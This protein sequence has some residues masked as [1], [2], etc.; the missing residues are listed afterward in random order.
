MVSLLALS[1]TPLLLVNLVFAA[2]ALAVGFAAGAWVCGG[3]ESTEGRKDLS[4]EDA[5]LE[6]ER[7]NQ[8]LERTVMASDRL[9][10]LAVSVASDVGSHNANIGLIEAQLEQGRADG[11][12]NAELVL[13]AIDE[14]EQA[15]SSLQSKLEKAEQQIKA[16]A[17]QIKTHESEAR[18]D[19]LTSLANRRA[20]DDELARRLAEW[21]RLKTPFSLL[22]MDVDHFKQFNDTHGHLAGDEVLRQVGHAMIECAREMDLPCRYGGEEFAII[23]PATRSSDGGV[24]AERLRTTIETMQVPFEGKKLSV[25]VSMGLSGTIE[26]DSATELVKRADEALYAS[27]DAG[28]N[29]THLNNGKKNL[30]VTAGGPM[31]TLSDEVGANVRAPN[32][33]SL[34]NRTRFLELIRNEIRVAKRCESPL[35]LLVT[36]FEGYQRI[37][38]EFGEAV[39]NLTLDSISQFLDNAIQENDQLCQLGANQFFILMPQHSAKEAHL[40]GERINSALS[41][42]AIPL[43]TE[44]LRLSMRISSVELD[45]QDTGT[46]LMK[47]AERCFTTPTVTPA[48]AV[49][50]S[51]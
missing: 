16:Q 2:I 1:S 25:T 31:P 38:S 13:R 7:Q 40:A 24:L 21:E 35:A 45:E 5:E 27:K 4:G 50:V 33:D 18:T 29:K 3:K 26:G 42:C 48:Q 19:S 49:G 28:R 44:E 37:K 11:T 10:D 12:Q 47:R 15:N 6:A 46:S 17:E 43:G 32:L 9:R 22:I 23:L 36:E 30:L 39:A 8:I 41:K 51:G 14:I 20:F 34:P